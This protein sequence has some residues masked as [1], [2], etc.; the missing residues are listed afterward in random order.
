MALSI[1]FSIKSFKN[2]FKDVIKTDKKGSKQINEEK[3]IITIFTKSRD[4]F[5]QIL[6]FPGNPYQLSTVLLMI[7]SRDSI[8]WLI[9]LEFMICYLNPSVH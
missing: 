6:I 4:K 1:K 5:I 3:A 8:L 2:N 7:F 9:Y